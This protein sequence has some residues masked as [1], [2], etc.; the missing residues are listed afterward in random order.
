MRSCIVAL[1]LFLA[2]AFPVSAAPIE[3]DWTITNGSTLDFDFTLSVEQIGDD[4]LVNFTVLNDGDVSGY[5]RG[6]GVKHLFDDE[7]S[8]AVADWLSVTLLD[9]GSTSDVSGSFVGGLN[10]K[11]S[12]SDYCKEGENGHDGMVC[13]E[14]TSAQTNNAVRLDTGDSLLFEFLVTGADVN[15]D[16]WHLQTKVFSGPSGNAALGAISAD[17][18]PS[19]SVPEPGT[20]ALLGLGFGAVRLRGAR[21]SR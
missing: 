7:L 11:T 16:Y 3:A 18:E 6:F 2:G 17:A 8:P 4:Y 20:L 10:L 5:Y 12:Q 15:L 1:A 14:L 13:A 9:G 21:R 19:T